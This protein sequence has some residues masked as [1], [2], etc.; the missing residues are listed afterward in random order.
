MPLAETSFQQCDGN[1]SRQKIDKDR[2]RSQNLFV[3][4]CL[5]FLFD[6]LYGL[7]QL[8]KTKLDNKCLTKNLIKLMNTIYGI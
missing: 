2:D 1:D 4:V 6:K 8:N 5:T 3:F 7:F